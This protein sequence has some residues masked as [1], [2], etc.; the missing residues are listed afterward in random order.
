MFTV[1][2]L[3]GKIIYEQATRRGFG[4]VAVFSFHNFSIVIDTDIY[5]LLLSYI[6][7]CLLFT[8]ACSMRAISARESCP[9]G[10]VTSAGVSEK[11][12]FKLTL[13]DGVFGVKTSKNS[14]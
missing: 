7:I 13:H 2:F 1:C 4:K 9:F 11:A 6:I 12:Y 5:L 8:G 3:D 14:A 10:V